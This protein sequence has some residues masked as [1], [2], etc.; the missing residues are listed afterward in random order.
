MRLTPHD[1]GTIWLVAMGLILVILMM[2]AVCGCA[3]AGAQP[4]SHAEIY[5]ALI[6]N[7]RHM[8]DGYFDGDL[9]ANVQ[10][11]YATDRNRPIGQTTYATPISIFVNSYYDRSERE[12]LLTEDHEMCHVYV[13]ET[14]GEAIDHGPRWV[15]C[16]HRLAD[17]GAFDQLW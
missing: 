13:Y 14:G 4:L 6:E 12:A 5:Q 2:Y 3:I 8:N 11:E 7:Y 17:E 1:E 10:I 15:G 16:M 9:P